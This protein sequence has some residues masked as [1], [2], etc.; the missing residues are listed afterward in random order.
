LKHCLNGE[1]KDAWKRLP[2]EQQFPYAVL[3]GNL[4]KSLVNQS[5][6]AE[7]AKRAKFNMMM[8]GSEQSVRQFVTR[9]DLQARHAYPASDY[10]RGEVAQIKM[11][12]LLVGLKLNDVRVKLISAIKD[13]EEG[14]EE[15]YHRLAEMALNMEETR[16]GISNMQHLMQ[17]NHQVREQ[18]VQVNSSAAFVGTRRLTNGEWM[19][20]Q[21]Y[22]S[23]H[24]KGHF[25]RDCPRR[26]GN[27]GNSNEKGNEKV[28][29]QNNFELP[30]IKSI[31]VDACHNRGEDGLVKK[32]SNQDFRQSAVRRC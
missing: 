9:L 27:N 32:E 30:W 22:Y 31:Q 10:G 5:P 19:S 3:I 17:G 8:Q 21:E 15:R 13:K 18:Q 4:T 7:M 23:C 25:T 16:N 6:A 11:D 14:H 12:R 26:Y 20:L 2:E 1:A 29:E 28:E 24:G